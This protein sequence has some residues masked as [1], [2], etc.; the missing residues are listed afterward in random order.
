MLHHLA[1]TRDECTCAHNN[2]TATHLKPLIC[3][4]PVCTAHPS[5]PPGITNKSQ[6]KII[7]PPIHVCLAI[8]PSCTAC[9]ACLY[10]LLLQQ[11]LT[12]LTTHLMPSTSVLKPSRRGTVTTRAALTSASKTYIVKVG[13]Q[14]T[15]AS[16]G[17]NVQRINR[18]INS[19]APQPTCSSDTC[20]IAWLG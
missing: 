5:V 1:A 3:V 17:S 2:R 11:V 6:P 8:Q 9:T 14:S 15:M 13:G 20:R 12:H 19:S 7:L 18:S 10:C 4:V 16:P